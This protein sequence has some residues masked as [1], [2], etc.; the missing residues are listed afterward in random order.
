MCIRD[1]SKTGK[2]HYQL[3][4]FPHRKNFDLWFTNNDDWDV[5]VDPRNVNTARSAYANAFEFG[6]RGFATRGILSP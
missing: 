5:D 1:R 4:S 2:R 6:P 3:Q